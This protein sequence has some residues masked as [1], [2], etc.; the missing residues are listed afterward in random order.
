MVKGKGK[1]SKKK[2]KILAASDIHGSSDDTKRLAER[3]EK[4]NVDLVILAGDITAP[5]ETKNII[6]PFIDKG[7]K[8]LLIPGNHEDFATADFLARLYGVKNIH[9][10]SVQYENVGIFGAGGADIGPG[11]ISESQLSSVLKK[12]HAGLKEHG[13]GIEKKILVTHMHPFG[14]KAEFSGF[15]GSK[16]IAKAIKEFQ[17]DLMLCGHIHEAEGIEDKIGKTKILN[18]GRKGMIIEL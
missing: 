14:S 11:A 2:L 8:V 3:A 16:A 10:Y 18:I 6:K 4:E 5:F 13:R 9:G 12:A 1:K 7:K 15:E 17:P